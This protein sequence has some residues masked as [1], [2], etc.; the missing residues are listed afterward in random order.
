M[1]DAVFRPALTAEE[2][3]EK[4][5]VVNDNE[6]QVARVLTKAEKELEAKKRK[7][8]DERIRKQ[9]EDDAPI[10]ALQEMMGGKLETKK[11]Q[12]LS[13]Q[14][15]TKE[16][17]MSLPLDQLTEQQKQQLDEYNRKEQMVK[18]AR[19]DQR[20]QLES[21]L[22]MMR[23]K[24]RIRM[25]RRRRRRK[26]GPEAK[27]RWKA[28]KN[29]R[30][31]DMKLSQFCVFPRSSLLFSPL[32]LSLFLSLFFCICCSFFLFLLRS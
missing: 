12:A 31:F 13:E 14:E 8:E 9:Q 24:R 29:H 30:Q 16:D 32:L 20:K 19:D 26:G 18:K 28:D 10:R 4:G 2:Q 17:W 3:K 7:E 22:M 15:I 27:E 25:M 21:G 11:D 1:G 6:I 5:L 23:M